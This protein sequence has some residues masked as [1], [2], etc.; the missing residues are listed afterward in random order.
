MKKICVVCKK[1]FNTSHKKVK[2]CSKD[3]GNE[4]KR[5]NKYNEMSEKVNEDFKTWL[6][7]KYEDEMLSVRE[8]SVILYG[9]NFSNF[10]SIFISL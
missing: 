10:I 5:I 8:I 7:R 1:E 2:C 9:N 4:L 6:K 3:C